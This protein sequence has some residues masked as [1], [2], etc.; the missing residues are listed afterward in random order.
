MKITSKPKDVK[1]PDVPNEYLNHFIRG[2]FDGEGHIN[3]EKRLVSFVGGSLEFMKTLQLILEK[4]M[5]KP[6]IRKQ[7]NYFRL[8]L[9]GRRSIFLFGEWIYQ[10]KT[11]YFEKKFKE[12][13]KETKSLCEMQDR[14]IKSTQAAVQERKNN[15][16]EQLERKKPINEICNSVQ[17][18]IQ[19]YNR[20]LLQDEAFKQRVILIQNE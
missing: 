11:I 18:K 20:W 14:K 6:Y 19:T 13:K 10:N 8:F 4:Q 2:Y 5:F 3:Y 15:F 1:M 17:I 7:K 12:F 9:T 16:I